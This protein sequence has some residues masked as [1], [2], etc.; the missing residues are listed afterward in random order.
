MV[1][2]VYSHL[3]MNVNK[4]KKLVFSSSGCVNKYW[5]NILKLSLLSKFP[6]VYLSNNTSMH[7]IWFQDPKLPAH[8]VLCKKVIILF[9]MIF[10]ALITLN[11]TSPSFPLRGISKPYHVCPVGLDVNV[12]AKV[13]EISTGHTNLEFL[14]V[15]NRNLGLGLLF[16]RRFILDWSNLHLGPKKCD[17]WPH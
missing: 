8:V 12:D 1:S 10:H 5:I 14:N 9:E 13:C 11:S 3:Y 17:A 7:I 4:T 16:Q 6:A 2:T 15:Y